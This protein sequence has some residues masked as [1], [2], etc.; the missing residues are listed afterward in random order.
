[1]EHSFVQN[2]VFSVELTHLDV[3]EHKSRVH[4]ITVRF[5]DNG[6]Q[7]VKKDN[8]NQELIGEPNDPDQIDA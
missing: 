2:G 3:L 7:E 5:R 8:Q 6:N 1:L 4:D